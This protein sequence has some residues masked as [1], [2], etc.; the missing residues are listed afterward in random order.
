MHLE[1][2]PLLQ[3][4]GESPAT[5][6]SFTALGE[7]FTVGDD[8]V[9]RGWGLGDAA[10]GG[11]SSASSSSSS[12]SS[13]PLPAETGG[14][15]AFAWLHARAAGRRATSD[16]FALG[17]ADG[18]VRLVARVG[19]KVERTLA[20][21]K[22]AVTGVAWAP[23][24]Q[25]LAS[26]GEDGAVKLWSRAGMLRATLVQGTQPVYAVAWAGDGSAVVH[27][28][29]GG[30]AV[31]ARAAGRKPVAWRAHDGLVLAVDWCPP[32]AAGAAAAIV[33]CG[34]DGRFKLWDALGRL[35]HASAPAAA[36]LTSVAWSPAGDAFVVGGFDHLRLCDAAGWT[37]AVAPVAHG[38]SAYSVRWSPDGTR[39]VAA[40]ASGRVA[41]AAV[42][43]RR[44]EAGP[45]AVVQ[46]APAALEVRDAA[47]A[48]DAA[49]EPLRG[50]SS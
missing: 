21:H 13:A 29:G 20:A 36:P 50:E 39:V 11:A 41:A 30:L 42:L 7:A 16:V 23:D 33:S 8:H 24:G 44:S 38:G 37:H 32:G 9:L 6:V 17:G 18:N 49:P 27:T 28:D 5:G 14:P 25:V 22:A 48:A 3:G 15:T 34:E 4:H 26:C 19:G 10:A 31:R 45:V 43:G 40:L 1:L 2:A 46:T 12:S 47:A 35:L